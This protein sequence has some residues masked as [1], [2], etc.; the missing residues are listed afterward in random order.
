[1]SIFDIFKKR[2]KSICNNKDKAKIKE[3]FNFL[4]LDYGF[5]FHEANLGN[6]VDENGKFFFYGPV[7]C[8]SIYNDKVCI[9]I[10]ELVQRHDY[11]IFIT[12]GLTQDQPTIRRG[13]VVGA[14]YCYRWQEFA[15][16]IKQELEEKGTIYGIPVT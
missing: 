4:L 14:Y 12:K 16:K 6:A 8:Y 13:T 3:I 2:E 15:N 5:E 7:Y 10:L 11:E 9:N 1:M